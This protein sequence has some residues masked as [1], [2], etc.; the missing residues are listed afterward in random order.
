MKAFSAIILAAGKGTRLKS[1][2][3]KPLVEING[4]PLIQPILDNCFALGCKNICVVISE[5]TKAIKEH[6]PDPRITYILTE[7][8]GTGHGALVALPYVIGPAVLIAHADDSFFYTQATLRGILTQ[9]EEDG[10]VCTC[11]VATVTRPAAYSY[12]TSDSKNNLLALHRTPV[13]RQKLPPKDVFC[14]LYV[15]EI[16]WL[17]STLPE[18]TKPAEGEI[19]LPDIV[20]QALDKKQKITVFHIPEKEW[21]GINT[22]EELAAARAQAAQ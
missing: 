9:H 10:S 1:P 15:A 12:V 2:V 3:P 21:L 11:G 22:P 5:Y 6:Y 16:T 20:L 8:K 14:G 13:D 7:P 4:T 18:I 19:P 17:A